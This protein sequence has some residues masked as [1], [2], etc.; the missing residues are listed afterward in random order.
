M[1]GEP[2]TRELSPFSCQPVPHTVDDDLLRNLLASILIIRV[3]T[4]L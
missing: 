2:W 4:L 1:S 3:V